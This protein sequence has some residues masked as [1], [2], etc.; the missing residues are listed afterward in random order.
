[1]NQETLLGLIESL[2]NGDISPEDRRR[3]QTLLKKSAIARAIFHER[4]D[5][6]AGLRSWALEESG[7]QPVRPLPDE[8]A[9]ARRPIEHGSGRR[10]RN[11]IVALAVACAALLLLLAIPLLSPD[12]SGTHDVAI[13]DAS[14]DAKHKPRANTSEYFGSVRAGEG[15]NWE[16]PRNASRSRFQTGAY[17][18][19]AGVAELSFD[20]GTDLILEAPCEITVTAS[21]SARLIAGNVTVNVSDRSDVFTLHTPE[22]QII[23]EGTEYAVSVSAETTE[24]HVFDGSVFWIPDVVGSS[25]KDRIEAGEARLYSHDDP[26][27][28]KRIPFGQR[29]FV[30]R[31]ESEIQQQAGDALLAYDGFENLAG[32]L[33]RGRSGFGWSGGWQSGRRGRG[34]LAGVI[35]APNDEVFGLPRSGRRLLRLTNGDNILRALEQPLSMTPGSTYYVS[36]LLERLSGDSTREQPLQISLEP[37]AV[38]RRRRQAG[39]SFGITTDGFPYIKNGNDSQEAASPINHAETCLCVLQVVVTERG[40]ASN[41]RLYRPHEPI[42]KNVPAVWTVSTEPQ[43]SPDTEVIRLSVGSN[44]VWLIDELKVGTEWHSV[45]RRL[46]VQ[47]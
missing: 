47:D 5:L 23:D 12:D 43:P 4:M 19:T 25:V 10:R 27:R 28:P 7:Q 34:R 32:H 40:A 42:E 44:A 6:E 35:D 15:A 1:M 22:S 39:V 14:T 26:T 29:Q 33:R 2:V 36:L 38:G 8:A 31:I 16:E 46:V 18:L 17:S 45:T 3:L 20:S 37:E 13:D 11:V 9:V 24:V 21:N 41:L 30:R